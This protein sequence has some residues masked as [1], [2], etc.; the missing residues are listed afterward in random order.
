MVKNGEN[1]NMLSVFFYVF[2]IKQGK[3]PFWDRLIVNIPPI[4]GYD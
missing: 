4:R 1:F 2:S 3:I